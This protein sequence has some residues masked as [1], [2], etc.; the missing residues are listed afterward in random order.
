M[1]LDEFGFDRIERAECQQAAHLFYKI[2]AVRNQK[3]STALVANV[4]F[5]KW[6]DYMS[7]GPLAM[8]FPDR[9]VEGAIILKLKDKSYREAP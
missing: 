9:I 3:R 1:V 5:D 8:A 4:D 2:I 6:V 7:A